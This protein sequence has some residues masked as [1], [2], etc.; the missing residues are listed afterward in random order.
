MLLQT[1]IRKLFFLIGLHDGNKD[2]KEEKNPEIVKEEL[3]NL[4]R[5]TDTKEEQDFNV[6]NRSKKSS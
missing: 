1:K 4:L 5:G 2:Q 3:S 6:L